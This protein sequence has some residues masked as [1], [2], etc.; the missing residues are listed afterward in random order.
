MCTQSAEGEPNR[1]HRREARYRTKSAGGPKQ[2]HSRGETWPI[3]ARE[4]E[5][6][7]TTENTNITMT[8][9]CEACPK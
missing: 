7:P 2:T 4:G 3:R 1:A 6:K 8:K 5:W 9:R